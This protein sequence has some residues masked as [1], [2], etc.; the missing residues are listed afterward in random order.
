MTLFEAINEFLKEMETTITVW[1]NDDNEYGACFSNRSKENLEFRE[2]GDDMI[3]IIVKAA[4]KAGI[5]DDITVTERERTVLNKIAEI[6]DEYSPFLYLILSQDTNNGNFDGYISH[7]FGY[8]GNLGVATGNVNISGDVEVVFREIASE[9][10]LNLTLADE[11]DFFSRIAEYIT[12]EN[13]SHSSYSG[14]HRAYNA[15]CIMRK[16]NNKYSVLIRANHTQ[17]IEAIESNLNYAVAKAISKT[18]AENQWI[19]QKALIESGRG[20]SYALMKIEKV[21]DQSEPYTAFKI[22][23]EVDKKFVPHTLFA[24]L[25]LYGHGIYKLQFVNTSK[26]K[27]FVE[28]ISRARGY[29]CPGYYLA[30][31]LFGAA[32]EMESIISKKQSQQK[33]IVGF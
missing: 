17:Q 23:E 15:E 19:T 5:S 31:A 18:N 4:K 11:R 28:K 16:K 1:K 27:V 30:R 10:R 13:M 12:H 29:T 22:S 25:D 3:D 9:S 7:G 14:E 26:H 6:I 32:K 24:D 2:I 21:L 20:E 8:L 33:N